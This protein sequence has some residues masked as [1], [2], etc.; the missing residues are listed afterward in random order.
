MNKKIGTDSR[1]SFIHLDKLFKIAESNLSS[2]VN[3][4]ENEITSLIKSLT[5]ESPFY[6]PLMSYKKLITE[7]KSNEQFNHYFE[8]IASIT[9]QKHFFGSE[10]SLVILTNQLAHI[11]KMIQ[12][13]L[14]PKKR[15]SI[16]SEDIQ[17]LKK[18]LIQERIRP[19]KQRKVV[20]I[21]K[22]KTITQ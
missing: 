9:T 14:T 4:F 18:G 1:R 13:T 19:I 10:E 16:T 15:E 20:K 21:V 8:K 2:N 17:N 7:I 5:K 12:D 3:S 6:S 22:K 11:K